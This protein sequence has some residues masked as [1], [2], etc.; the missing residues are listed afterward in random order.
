[1]IVPDRAVTA[2][3]W[4]DISSVASVRM[5]LPMVE[6]RSLPV[7]RTVTAAEEWEN[8]LLRKAK[9]MGEWCCAYKGKGS[10]ASSGSKSDSKRKPKGKKKK[11]KSASTTSGDDENARTVEDFVESEARKE[12]ASARD[13][14]AFLSEEAA[15]TQG[16]KAGAGGKASAGAKALSERV[17]PSFLT[18][19]FKYAVG[20]Q[21]N[22]VLE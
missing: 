3:D 16:K 10:A 21:G 6:L 20:V 8:H 11:K 2:V 14:D 19:N 12:D 1:M 9:A 4:I 15:A 7:E 22:V 17:W 5:L 18:L 13:V